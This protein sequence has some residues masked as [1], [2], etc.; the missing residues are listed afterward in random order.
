MKRV[1]ILI[2]GRG[3]NMQS[4][5]RA[6]ATEF[7]SKYRGANITAVISNEPDAGGLAFAQSA[8]ITTH[9]VD[10]RNFPDRES[11]DL[12][13]INII[14]TCADYV[15]LA[16][17]MRIL[18]NRFV[19][20]YQGRLLNIHP[21]LLPSYPGLNTHQRAI[22]AHDT[23]AGASVHFVIPALDSGPV[24]LQARVPIEKDDDATTL[25]ARVLEKEHI[26]Y[27]LALRWVLEGSAF[28]EQ[29]AEGDH[30]CCYRNRRLTN[31]LQL[32][33]VLHNEDS[34][35]AQPD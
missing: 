24:I 1:A 5:V 32:D 20:R 25:A 35:I 27:P 22:E 26:I 33:D 14:D 17:Y 10:H 4:L 31:P 6:V 9:C 16:G 13:L 29:T 23:H 18:T 21:S 15:I 30:H 7:D 8:D 34:H 2:S 19:G 28:L 3:S 12:A 11:H